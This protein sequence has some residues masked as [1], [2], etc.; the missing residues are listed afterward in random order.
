MAVF[1]SLRVV[2]THTILHAYPPIYDDDAIASVVG[3]AGIVVG[4]VVAGPNA[5]SC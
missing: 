2:Y 5:Q 1:V 4:V 3:F